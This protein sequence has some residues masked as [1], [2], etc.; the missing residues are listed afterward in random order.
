M[1]MERC[2]QLDPDSPESHYRLARIY[3]RLGLATM[4]SEQNAA[5][6]EAAQRQSDANNRRTSTITRFLVLLSDSSQSDAHPSE[7]EP[8]HNPRVK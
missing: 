6:K 5:Q 1:Q 7:R 3:R 8:S 2:V 4:A